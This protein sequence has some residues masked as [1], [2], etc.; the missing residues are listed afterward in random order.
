MRIAG[1]A[2]GFDIPRK[3]EASWSAPALWRYPKALQLDADD[4]PARFFC[5]LT[6][7]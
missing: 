1:L 4:L 2:R 5:A 7:S 6:S 3:R